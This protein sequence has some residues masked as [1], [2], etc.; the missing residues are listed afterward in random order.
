MIVITWLGTRVEGVMEYSVLK[1]NG[2]Q[3]IKVELLRGDFK[4]RLSNKDIFANLLL[5]RLE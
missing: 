1:I 3:K 2:T 4:K 5:N